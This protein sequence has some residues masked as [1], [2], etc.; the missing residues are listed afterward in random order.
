MAAK[1]PTY[2]VMA[3]NAV[4]CLPNRAGKGVSLPKIKEQ[5]TEMYPLDSINKK[6]LSAALAKSVK[7][8]DLEK[9]KASYKLSDAKKETMPTKA[10]IIAAAKAI[11]EGGA[12][13]AT[14][15][16]TEVKVSSTYYV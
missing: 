6:A 2:Y 13:A 15:K 9:V 8:G 5:I 11:S 12:P 3:I 10:K 7:E 1:A 14:A 16:K 4:A